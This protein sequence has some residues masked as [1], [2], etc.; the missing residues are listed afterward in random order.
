MMVVI[1]EREL[2]SR[3]TPSPF[4]TPRKMCRNKCMLMVMHIYLFGHYSH[5][6]LQSIQVGSA[7][8]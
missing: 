3:V 5:H 7:I 4:L 6:L 2:I 8:S 1:C